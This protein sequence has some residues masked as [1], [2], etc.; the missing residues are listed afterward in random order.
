M[1]IIAITQARYGSTRLPGKV[2]KTINNISLLQIHVERIKKSK[3]IDQFIVATTF[4]PETSQ[5]IQIALAQGVSTFQGSTQ[6]VL[7]RF[8]KAAQKEQ[9]DYVVRL[10][11]D[12]PLI[13]AE[14]IDA[15]IEKCINENLDYCSNTLE[16]SFPDGC[17]IEIFRFS[18]LEQAYNNAS[19]L[20]E[21]EHVTPFIWKNSSFLGGT[22]FKSANYSN[23]ENFSSYRLTVDEIADFDLISKLVSIAGYH[24][25]WTEYVQILKGDTELFNLNS[26]F[27]RNEG[28]QK[29]MENDKIELRKIVNFSESEKY[30]A[31]I[32][33]L[34]PGGAHTYSKGDD[35]FPEKA[36]AAIKYGK[37]A[38]VWDVDDNKFLDC[39]MGLTSVSLG[40]GYDAV[41]DS[42]KKEVELGVNFQR[43]SAL[44]KEM[45]EKFLSIVPQHDMV[46]FAKNGSIVTTA[47]VKLARAFT[48]RQLVAFPGDHPFYSYDDWFIGRTA[49]NKG[50][51]EEISELSV[52][53][54]SCNIDSL[55]E[56]FEKHP[57]QI[58]CVIMEPEKNLCSNGCSCS[59]QVGEYLKQAIELTKQNGALFIMDE[60]VTGFKTG[61]PGSMKKYNLDPDMA[62]WGKGIANGFSFCALTGKKEVMEL[63][64]ITR[65][66]SEKVFLISTTHGGETHTMAAAIATINEFQKYDVI[67]HN[68]TLGKQLI[69]LCQEI[70]KENEL[71]DYI[72]VSTS[73][74]MP[75]FLFKDEQKQIS[76]A[77]RTLALQEMIKRGVLFQGIFTPCF[78]HTKEDI[79]YF[80]AAFKEMVTVY[81]S[82]LKIGYSGLLIGEPIKPVFRK[83]I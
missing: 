57:G 76:A 83:I 70:I 11:S 40:H 59:L 63:G 47:A 30:K 18:A 32:H 51:P 15:V 28:L 71:T 12:C 22:Y 34:I 50:V 29:S 26:H 78:S 82:A 9:P 14:V 24:A 19:L 41:V 60:M 56:L 36:P 80:A 21:K 23:P 8:Y 31:A 55:K 64:G 65:S 4:E 25:K 79:E 77:F 61:F 16:P 44:E 74:W 66:G 75:L 58:A 53:F 42:V 33:K 3:K 49:C 27:I 10:T 67:G 6:N 43:P 73:E 68:H 7:E 20:S 2:L 1:K 46:K 48:G 54:K 38:Y 39:S 69:I 72:Q 35:Q 62:T 81:K 13:D 5:I 45:A 52:T 17:D 37:G